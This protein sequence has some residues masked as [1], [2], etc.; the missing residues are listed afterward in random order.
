MDVLTENIEKEPPW[1]MMFADDLVLCAMTREELDEDLETWRVLFETH[2]LK[3]SRTKTEYLPSPTNDT[4]TT[5][6]IVDAELPTVTSF[7]Y[8][9][10]LFTSE[11]GPQ[12]DVND[13]IRIGWMKWKEVSGVMCDRKVPVKLKDKVF[14]TIIRP[15]MTYGS[16]CWAV[17]KKDE[18]KLNSAEMMILIWAR[19]KTRLDHIRN[20]DTRKEADVKPV[21]NKRLFKWFGHCLRRE[22]NHICAVS[23]RRSRGRPKKRWRDNI[24]GDMKKYQLTEDMAQ[25]R[26]YWMTKILAGPAQ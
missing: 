1:A 18:N 4:E 22:R 11:G 17:K 5:V 7:K 15:A 13:R 25:D 23:V 2:G 26:K 24:Q 19:G 16:E 10:L 20:E 12:A 8:V 3:I 14:K 21:E 6:K 9:G